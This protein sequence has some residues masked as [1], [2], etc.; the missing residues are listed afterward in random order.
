MRRSPRRDNVPR[1]F[2]RPRQR[3]SIGLFHEEEVMR[4]RE[5]LI[6]AT[7]SVAL[8]LSATP[9]GAKVTSM[10]YYGQ[11]FGAG[12]AYLVDWNANGHANVTFSAGSGSGTYTDDGTQRLITV[13]PP[14]TTTQTAVDCNG[15]EF[16][17]QVDYKQFVFRPTGG[18]NK[19]GTAQV[20]LIG[21]TTDLGGCTPGKKHN[22]GKPGDPGDD[23]DTL[24]MADRASESDLVPGV[25]LACFAKD[26]GD[27]EAPVS[28]VTFGSGTLT[29]DGADPIAY[30]VVNGWIVYTLSDNTQRAYT[31]LLQNF[32]SGVQT[33]LRADWADG[34]PSANPYITPCVTPKAGAGFGSTQATS[35][36]WNV[37]LWIGSG[38]TINYDLY[39]D[40]TGDWIVDD[41]SNKYDYPITWN[42]DAQ[43]T[44]H[45]LRTNRDRSLVPI[46]NYGKNH[47][48][49]ESEVWNVNGQWEQAIP[50]RVNWFIDTGASTP[51]GGLG[52]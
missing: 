11:S 13:K 16:D 19:S 35:R 40:F 22:F 28:N 44:L 51:P 33:W 15:N 34:Q 25:Q 14:I 50:P 43:A 8:S 29:F 37:G 46:A 5:L 26:P 31:R 38:T 9:A 21:T 42:M 10:A 12:G 36:N 47:F 30:S 49:Y 1:H 27:F 39:Q 48:V 6:G 20:V 45:I 4:I 3:R 23:V 7:M 2:N 41:G 18:T 24:N 32:K 52:R 17:Q